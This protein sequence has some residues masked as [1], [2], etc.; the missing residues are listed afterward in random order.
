M[1]LLINL[2]TVEKELW[3]CC[4]H[5]IKIT[6]AGLIQVLFLN[7]VSKKKK[8]MKTW[9]NMTPSYNSKEILSF[10]VPFLYCLGPGI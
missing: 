8:K 3:T 10:F 6:K 5:T 4:D 9:N 1:P 2:V 7:F